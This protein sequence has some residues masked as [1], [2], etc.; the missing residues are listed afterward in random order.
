MPDVGVLR[1]PW[2]VVERAH[3]GFF[4][5]RLE[6]RLGLEIHE[7]EV[8]RAVHL[9][10]RA[11]ERCEHRRPAARDEEGAEQ[12][13]LIPRVED[14]DVEALEHVVV[15]QGVEPAVR[16]VERQPGNRHRDVGRV[17]Q[18]PLGV[19]VLD[20]AVR[21]GAR[22]ERVRD[23]V[24]RETALRHLEGRADLVPGRDARDRIQ[25][26]DAVVA[27]DVHA[28]QLLGPRVVGAVGR[29]VRDPS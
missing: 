18:R 19:E 17:Q 16:G 12:R 29:E 23:D 8:A 20:D 3:A 28:P 1:E 26:V 14:V 9:H 22:V 2:D 27:A 21:P 11:A 24:V 6:D 4:G 7:P 5:L 25:L 15:R 10:P 13:V